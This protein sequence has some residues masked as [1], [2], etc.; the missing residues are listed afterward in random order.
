MYIIHIANL[1]GVLTRISLAITTTQPL[2]QGMTCHEKENKRD[3]PCLGL[4]VTLVE[5]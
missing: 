5:T 3:D 4:R 1:L 2:D